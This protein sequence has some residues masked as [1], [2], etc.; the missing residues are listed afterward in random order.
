MN[1]VRHSPSTCSASLPFSN[2]FEVEYSSTRP[3]WNLTSLSSPYQSIRS[4]CH[5]SSLAQA[6]SEPSVDLPDSSTHLPPNIGPKFAGVF[7]YQFID[8]LKPTTLSEPS[9]FLTVSFFAYSVS[10]DT[11]FGGPSRPAFLSMSAL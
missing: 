10:S 7:E 4:F 5:V 1:A 6:G 9:G 8:G 3:A 2:A 11:V